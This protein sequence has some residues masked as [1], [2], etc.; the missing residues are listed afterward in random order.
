MPENKIYWY[1]L[2]ARTG[3]EEKLIQS[4]KE[5]F[6]EKIRP[7]V[8]KKVCVFRRKGKKTFF[9]KNCFPGYVFIESS[10][11][12]EEFIE[13]AFRKVYKYKEAYRFLCYGDRYDI[14]MRDEER[15]ALSKVLGTERR[16]GIS[17]GFK[18]G[19]AMRCE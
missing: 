17:I 1:V 16:I 18:E 3:S 5:E 8:P 11:K 4:L 9:E 19:D 15:A 6:G 13:F 10:K 7:F 12:A 14:A 2:F